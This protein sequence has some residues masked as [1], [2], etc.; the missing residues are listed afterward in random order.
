MKVHGVGQVVVTIVQ[1]ALCHV[2]GFG[3]SWLEL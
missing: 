2:H 1:D 3:Q